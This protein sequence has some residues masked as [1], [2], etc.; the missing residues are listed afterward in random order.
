MKSGKSGFTFANSSARGRIVVERS[1]TFF[2]LEKARPMEA[3]SSSPRTS[4]V[5]RLLSVGMRLNLM[6]SIGLKPVAPPWL[7]SSERSIHH[8][9]LNWSTPK[10]C[11][12]TPRVHS[13]AV[14]WYS[15]TPMRLP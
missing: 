8:S 2:S 3:A 7:S 5:A 15:P 9:T 4:I 14:C 10:S 12:R 1:M 6:P 13:D 11:W